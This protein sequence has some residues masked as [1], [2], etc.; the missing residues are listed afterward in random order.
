MAFRPKLLSVN[1]ERQG[2][3]SGNRS[4]K[5][6]Q[7]KVPAI[8]LQAINGKAPVLGVDPGSTEECHRS[9]C[10]EKENSAGDCWGET[11]SEMQTPVKQHPAI[12]TTKH[13]FD[14]TLNTSFGEDNSFYITAASKPGSNQMRNAM[15]SLV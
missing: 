10:A 9:R 14:A 5:I 7:V 2:G 11:V 6:E 15:R 13:S 8:S 1:G 3:R 4:F 12:G